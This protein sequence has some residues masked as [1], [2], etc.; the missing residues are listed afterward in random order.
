MPARRSIR[1]ER[2]RLVADDADAA[3]SRGSGRATFGLIAAA[4]A[5]A[6]VAGSV[7]VGGRPLGSGPRGE[8]RGR[9]RRS[10]RLGSIGSPEASRPAARP[11]G[12][13]LRPVL[14][15][16]RHDRRPPRARPT[17]RRSPCSRSRTRAKGALATDAERLPRGSRARSA[18]GSS[19][20][21]TSADRRVDVTYTS[22][23]EAKNDALFAS[24][25]LQDAVIAALVELRAR[26]RRRRHR[27]RRRGAS[28]TRRSRPTAAFVGRLRTAL[29]ERRS[30]RDGHRR[31]RG[32][33]AGRRPGRSPRR[34]PAPT[35]S[36]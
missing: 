26:S 30:G 9:A 36:S 32:R 19:P 11:R 20:R 23:G 31:H 25:A 29:R 1:R 12:L 10:D 34:R 28:T 24:T 7:V 22:F 2:G 18:G 16:G 35:G 27:G 5:I 21:P 14:G 8:W 33:P 17:R 15:D 6:A 3:V 4:V 13:R